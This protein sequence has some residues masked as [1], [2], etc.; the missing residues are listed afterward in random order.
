M[1][2]VAGAV[3]EDVHPS[4]LRQE[5]QEWLIYD[6]IIE[7][8]SLARNYNATYG[9]IIHKEGMDSLLRKMDEKLAQKMEPKKK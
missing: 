5:G 1:T 6:V 9:E 8:V 7:G 3:E 4:E 2:A